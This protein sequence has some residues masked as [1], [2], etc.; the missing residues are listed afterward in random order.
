MYTMKIGGLTPQ[1]GEKAFGR[2]TA[3][4]SHGRFDVAVPLH[5][6]RGAA[7]G[8][9]LVVQAGLSGLEIEPAMILPK[10]V[11]EID[12]TSLRGTLV[13]VPL[14][15]TT[16]F[17]FEQVEAVWD[18]KDLHALG[19]GRADGTVSEELL[20]TYYEEVV[21]KADALVDVR[22]GAQ[23]GYYRYAGV[24]RTSSQRAST[25]LAASL[26]L[27]Q[28]LVG[29]PSVA[30]L[31]AAAAADGKTVVAA[32]IGGGPGLRD[33]REEDMARIGRA[34]HNALRHLGMLDG[35]PERS[36]QPS[37]VDAHTVL[38]PSGE[39]GFTFM[40]KTKRGQSVA[41]GERIGI[42]RHPFT[43]EVVQEITAPRAGVV[44]HAGASWPVV[45][46]G[47]TLA[48]LGDAVGERG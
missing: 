48:I 21:A 13:V 40:D 5:V 44:L 19:R 46:E 30:G 2:L 22:T 38:R 23:W 36:E 6:V 18:G 35:E 37:V 24:Y 43:G 3:T 15:N 41:A 8:P 42:V 7:D 27:P 14:F 32:W 9:T 33:H 45:P 28:V 1:P 29:E 34:V 4:K 11:D 12:T 20:H 17:E 16:G 25:A 10:L 31:A 39:R 47:F 26:D